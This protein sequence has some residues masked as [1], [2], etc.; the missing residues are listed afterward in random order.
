MSRVGEQPIT[1]PK[2]VSVSVEGSRVRI[3][4]PLG[5]LVQLIPPEIRVKVESSRVVVKRIN[6]EKRS[7][8][9]HG[10]LRTLIFNMT[11]GVERGW[12]KELELVGVGY[13]AFMKG[14]KLILEVGFSHPVEITPPPGIKLEVSKNKITVSGIDKALVGQVAA[15]IRAVRKPEPYKGKGLRYV[16]EKV[17]RKPGKAAKIGAGIGGGK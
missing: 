12:K 16:G 8:S 13:K 9:L 5:E 4:G 11:K 1:I 15:E 3:K 2:E 17:R 14:E 6:D 10:L 7:K